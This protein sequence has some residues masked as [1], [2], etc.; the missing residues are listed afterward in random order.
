MQWPTIY[1]KLSIQLPPKFCVRLVIAIQFIVYIA[2]S[3]YVAIRYNMHVMI[4]TVTC[5]SMMKQM[6]FQLSFSNL[7][8]NI[9][10][11]QLTRLRKVK[12]VKAGSHATFTIMKAEVAARYKFIFMQLRSCYC[13]SV[14][15]SYACMRRIDKLTSNSV[16]KNYSIYE[17]Q[18]VTIATQLNII[19][20]MKLLQFYRVTPL[21]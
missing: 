9:P 16:L 21:V 8:V 15:C 5:Y 11:Y 18:L 6:Y 17:S 7:A 12:S 3:M 2:V 10:F 19:S 13:K 20:Y 14:E 1:N 4:P